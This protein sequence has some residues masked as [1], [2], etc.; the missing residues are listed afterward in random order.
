MGTCVGLPREARLQDGVVRGAHPGHHLVDLG[1]AQEGTI[2]AGPPIARVEEREEEPLR[3]GIVGVPVGEEEVGI[4]LGARGPRRGRVAFEDGDADPCLGPALLQRHRQA[5]VL[6]SPGAPE[7][8][9]D[10]VRMAGG[11]EQRLRLGDVEGIWREGRIATLTTEAVALS[12]GADRRIA[13]TYGLLQTLLPLMGYGLAFAVPW[14]MFRNR[15]ALS[16]A[17]A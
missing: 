1:V 4:T 11:G 15:R 10:P 6:A 12:S 7:F 17:T 14:L 2:P 8:E 3:V 9:V 16:G 5:A 13:A